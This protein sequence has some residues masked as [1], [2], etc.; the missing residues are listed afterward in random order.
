MRQLLKVFLLILTICSFEKANSQ[1]NIDYI[2]DL[3]IFTE[4]QYRADDILLNGEMYFQ[5]H[6]KANG[7]PYYKTNEYLKADI[8]IQNKKFSN[9][10][11]KYDLEKDC[12]IT[13]IEKT[14][15]S[16]CFFVLNSY[17]IDSIIINNNKFVH[18]RL[19]DIKDLQVGYY[20]IIF[21][22]KI[23]F[24]SKHVKYF[25]ENYTNSNPYGVYSKQNTDYYIYY[26]NN[27][28]KVNKRRQL[29][30]VF[31]KEKKEIKKYMRKNKI[32]YRKANNSDLILLMIKIQ[33]L[34]D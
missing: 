29:L 13:E 19:I 5:K 20:E 16:L 9:K 32:R 22:S 8:Y 18:S 25:K 28:F 24:L 21:N 10:N 23:I 31:A 27:L 15:K 7:F 14:D 34:L 4:K 17:L 33:S 2:N 1:I 26:N 11:V 6:Y 12:F 30:N 3:F